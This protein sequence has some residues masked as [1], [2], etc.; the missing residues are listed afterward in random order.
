MNRLAASMR[1]TIVPA[2]IFDQALNHRNAYRHIL[3]AGMRAE[4]D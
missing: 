1:G 4:R 2:D 3:P